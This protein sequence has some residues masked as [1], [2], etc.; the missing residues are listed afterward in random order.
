LHQL[1]VLGDSS[2]VVDLKQFAA[3]GSVT[4]HGH[5]FNVYQSTVDQTLQV[6][7]DQQIAQ[8]HVYLS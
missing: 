2:D 5:T 3:N 4:Q 1:E 8:S 6:L 7:I